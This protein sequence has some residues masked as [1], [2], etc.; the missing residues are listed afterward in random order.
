MLL[1]ASKAGE[2]PSSN[3][4][5]PTWRTLENRGPELVAV[6]SAIV[7]LNIFTRIKIIKG[8]AL[9]HYSIFLSLVSIYVVKWLEVFRW[10]YCYF[11]HN[12]HS[13]SF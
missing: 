3:T 8:T 4:F 1:S 12:V 11:A 10:L 7:H 13:F 5:E 6:T 2:K 9:D